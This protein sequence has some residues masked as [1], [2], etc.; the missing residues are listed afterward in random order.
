MIEKRHLR[1]RHYLA[2][3]LF[4][5]LLLSPG[6]ASLPPVD[7]DEPR[8]MQATSQMLATGNFIDVRF[9]D[10]PRYLQPAGIYW[11]EAA[12]VTL[13][14]TPGVREPWAFR[15]PSLAGA[16]GATLLT[17]WIGSM[18]F[19]ATAGLMAGLLLG[20][21]VLLGFGS[22]LAT[23]DATL[24]PV[25]LLAQAM[26]LRVYLAHGPFAPRDP[27]LAP[28]VPGLPS[29]ESSGLRAAGGDAAGRITAL[30]FWAALGAGLMLKGPVILLVAG[31]TILGLLIADRR[32]GWLRHLHAGWGVLV[33]LAIVLPWCIGIATVSGG[34]FF[35]DAIG[36]NFLG[37]VASGQ[38]A[39]GLPPGYYMLAFG[40]SFWPGTL[41]ALPAVP[42]AWSRRR[43]V[44]V[45]FLLAWIL[46]TWL[47]FE[48]VQ[49]KLPHYV[50]PTYP[51][52]ACIIAAALVFGARSAHGV[53]IWLTRA[54]TA[55]WMLVA[56]GLVLAGPILLWRLEAR[57]A[58]LPML[59]GIAVLLFCAAALRL[60]ARHKPEGAV[61]CAA[62]A[63]LFLQCD[64]FSL[65]L[66][67]L[68][69][70]WLSPRIVKTVEAVR[71]CSNSVVA[72]ASYSE[73]SLVFLLGQQTRLINPIQSAE[74]LLSEPRCNL[75]LIDRRQQAE[76]LGR[77]AAAN[78]TPLPL[79]EVKGL[80]YSTGQRL[81]LILYSGPKEGRPPLPMPET[82]ASH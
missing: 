65:V 63:A 66:P 44:E 41:F 76:F 55:L 28:V 56:L 80:N 47:V 36:K 3:A 33:M 72:S 50:L 45:R 39:H 7:R 68:H 10:Q 59:V 34:T 4:A 42:F 77:L 16:V 70:V 11:L 31:G 82:E 20:A 24:L 60:A 18:L 46:P 35:T 74:F 22:R 26:L 78:V 51:A 30:L 17:A 62:V 64:V 75:A 14:G 27:L 8:Y 25:I 40:L 61:V 73:P 19:G 53:W 54:N 29:S 9:Q 1:F 48:L 43:T 38:Q 5:C 12:S 81:D 67:Q 52:I 69:S 23:I 32:A 58:W 21:S 6:R 37:K 79:A 57:L 2:L 13:F 71:P 15:L 49:T